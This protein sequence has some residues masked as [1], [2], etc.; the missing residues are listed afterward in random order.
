MRAKLGGGVAEGGEGAQH[1]QFALGSA[2]RAAGWP[3]A[4]RRYG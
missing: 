2:D 3:G 4:Q 1:Q